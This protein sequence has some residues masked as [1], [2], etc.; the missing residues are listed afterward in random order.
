MVVIAEFRAT[1]IRSMKTNI[2]NFKKGSVL[3]M[4]FGLLVLPVLAQQVAVKNISAA[5]VAGII[6]KEKAILIDV[7]TAGEVAQGFIK[8]T[9][10][11]IDVY[12][13][14]FTQ[15]IEKLDKNKTYIVYC[16]SG[17]RSTTASNIMLKQ[18]FK[19][20]YNLNGGILNWTGEIA[21]P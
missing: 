19:N 8:G 11:F 2:V 20:I 4:L 10:T 21:K 9:N 18:G 17:A 14:N 3:V 7:R 15:Q 5:D 6:K 12:S 1:K 16:R 13:S